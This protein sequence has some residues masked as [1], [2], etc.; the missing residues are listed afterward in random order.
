MLRSKPVP[1]RIAPLFIRHRAL[2]TT[3]PSFTSSTRSTSATHPKSKPKPQDP[4]AQFYSNSLH[5]P[6]TA[7][8]LR[9]DAKNRDGLFFERCTKALYE[10]QKDQDR[11][12]WVLHDG[13]P[14]ANGSLHTGHALNKIIKDMINRF[15]LISGYRIN[16]IPG[17]DTHGLPLELKALSTLGKPASSL[18]SQ[19]IRSAARKEA[20]AGVELQTNEFK[21]LGVMADW[22]G[23]YETLR[24][25]YEK[26]QLGVVREMVRKDLI[27]NHQRPTLYS[28]SSRTALAE[29][30][31]EYKEDHVSRSVYVG[32]KIASLGSELV[33]VLRDQ[34]VEESKMG[35]IVLAVWTTT[36]WTLPSNV[37]VAISETMDY[38]LVEGLGPGRLLVVATDRIGALSEIFGTKLKSV[39]QFSGSSLLRTT[40]LNPLASSNSPSPP[41]PIFPASYVTSIT[42]TGLVHTAPAHG[43]DDY[44][45][46]R[47]YQSSQSSQTPSPIFCAVD[48]D[49]KLIGSVLKEMA[50]DEA[51]SKRL[52]GKSVLGDGTGAMI[53]VLEEVGVLLKEVETVHKFPYDWRTKK[54]VIFRASGQWFANLEKVKDDAVKALENVSFHPPRGRLNLPC[55]QTPVLIKECDSTPGHKT[56]ETYVRGRSEWCISRQRAWGVPL[57]IVYSYPGDATDPIASSIPLLTPSN[58]D[59]IISVLDSHLQGTDYWWIGEAEEFVEPKELERSKKEGRAWRKGFDTMDVWFDSGTSWTLLRELGVR[60]SKGE[61]GKP[62]ADLYLEGSDQHRGWFQSSLLTAVAADGSGKAPYVNVLTHGM[63]LDEK[64]RKM[65]KSLGNVLSPA[66]IIQGGKNPKTQPAYG[67][68]LLRMWVASVDSTKD[69]LIGPSI[70]AQ[71]FETFRKIRNTARFILGNL[72]ATKGSQNTEVD[73]EVEQLGLIDRY[74]LHELYVLEKTTREAYETFNFSRVYQSLT[75]FSNTTLSSFYFDIIKDPLYSDPI[76]STRRQHIVYILNRVLDSYT[77]VLAPIAP[78]LAEEIHHF[79]T[80]ATR[81]PVAG[82]G[83]SASSVFEKLWKEPNERW[84]SSEAKNEMD[85]L[86]IV[87]EQVMGLLEQARA[88][89]LIGSSTEALVEI[90]NAS[91][92]VQKHCEHSRAVVEGDHGAPSLM[93]GSCADD[94]LSALFVVSDVVLSRANESRTSLEGISRS[95]D[96]TL[97]SGM[98]LIVTPSTNY[99]C[100][101]CR[102]HSVPKEKEVGH[103]CERC[104]IALQGKE[105]PSIMT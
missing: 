72:A 17:Y 32:F 95:F 70:L 3:L 8:P 24:W 100:P 63:V 60:S 81:D 28:P 50:V 5:L 1:S 56:L 61:E 37:A 21:T 39:A 52:E 101:R 14:Y 88:E 82:E 12:L 77:M 22:E 11:P 55:M 79:S 15:K 102:S 47:A 65:S 6:R 51:I 27:V 68:D 36:A 45:A 4:L 74:I 29:A 26:R 35:N 98:K 10:W 76:D 93:L 69:V 85:E 80:G 38:S 13:P 23:K 57:P 31:L 64:G 86:L 48:A 75:S 40:Y 33:E 97:P 104:E 2:H 73:I 7:F 94:S 67:V 46:Y 25:G 87:R 66:T 59:H 58:V 53:E 44:D 91:S 16:Y 19:Q 96:K 41:R 90:E 62:W 43:V 9:A 99:K 83:E 42:G 92:L 54:P 105:R 18:T 71:T 20:L 89:R 30:E 78:L 103:V 49:G 34:G 84:M